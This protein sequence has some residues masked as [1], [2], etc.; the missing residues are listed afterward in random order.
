MGGESFL[1]TKGWDLG[2]GK[3]GEDSRV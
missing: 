1:I 2:A 3:G